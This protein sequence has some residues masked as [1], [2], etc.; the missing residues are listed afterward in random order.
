MEKYRI[1]YAY[2]TTV[3]DENFVTDDYNELIT[4]IN[5]TFN[6]AARVEFYHVM[7]GRN[8]LLCSNDKYLDLSEHDKYWPI[9]GCFRIIYE[10]EVVDYANIFVYS[11]VI[12]GDICIIAS[13]DIDYSPNGKSI[14]N[15]K[16]AITVW[17]DNYLPTVRHKY[18]GYILK[19]ST[20]EKVTMQ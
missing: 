12:D 20:S 10:N 14:E 8:I 2:D 18:G 1:H 15:I 19:V 5:A 16:N 6:S 17:M 13:I 4:K 9:P 11:E 7:D 3:V